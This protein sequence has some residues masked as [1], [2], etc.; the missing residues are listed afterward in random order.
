MVR[1]RSRRVRSRNS[2]LTFEYVFVLSNQ[3]FPA[4]GG[5][6]RHREN[7][8]LSVWAIC[9]ATIVDGR[10]HVPC[11]FPDLGFCSSAPRPF[12]GVLFIVNLFAVSACRRSK[13]APGWGSNRI[14][15]GHS[16]L[17]EL[18]QICLK[19]SLTMKVVCRSLS[20]IGGSACD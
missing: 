19:A 20:F 4:G 6:H 1:Y 13:V 2:N 10:D 16:L 3:L 5:A 9:F 11:T 8:F 12:L 14:E 7:G 17:R 18:D 15:R